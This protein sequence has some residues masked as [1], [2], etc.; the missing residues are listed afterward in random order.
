MEEEAQDLLVRRL[1][2]AGE[3][4]AMD[5]VVVAHHGS[6][7]QVPRLY[8]LLRPRLALIGV[9]AEN[10]YGHPAPSTLSLLHRLGAADL[11]TDT[12]GLVAVCGTPD[13]LRV[14]TTR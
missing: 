2:S 4:A 11:R 10:D 9:G 14:A 8:E 12:R 3:G 5:V 1:R 6:A 13:H 7:R